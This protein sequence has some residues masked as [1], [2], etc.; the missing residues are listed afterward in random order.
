MHLLGERGKKS[1]P[2]CD[3]L[4]ACGL[5]RDIKRQGKLLL[6]FFLWLSCPDEG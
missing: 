1:N 5:F 4:R 2:Y 6:L 3:L